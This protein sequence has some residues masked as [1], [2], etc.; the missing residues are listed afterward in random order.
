MEWLKENWKDLLLFLFASVMTTLGIYMAV[1]IVLSNQGFGTWGEF[2][3]LFV[4]LN[5]AVFVVF[6]GVRT[7]L[8][9]LNEWVK[10]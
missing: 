4:V 9:I 5:F 10:E 7:Q 2:F 1:S 3:E 6:N 8:M